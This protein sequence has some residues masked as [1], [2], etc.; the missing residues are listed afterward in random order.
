MFSMFFS[1]KLWISL[2]FLNG[3]SFTKSSFVLYYVIIYY[4]RLSYIIVWNPTLPYWIG[5]CPRSSYGLLPVGWLVG[6]ANNPTNVQCIPMTS[7]SGAGTVAG[8]PAGLLDISI[9]LSL[10]LSFSLPLSLSILSAT[11]PSARYWS[12]Y[13]LV[14]ALSSPSGVLVLRAGPPAGRTVLI[15]ILDFFS[16]EFS[17]D[18][19][20][21]KIWPK[22]PKNHPKE[23]QRGTHWSQFP[24][25]LEVPL[26]IQK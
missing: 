8:L 12:A 21:P 16:I 2:S 7:C 26:E 5:Y 15:R 17:I 4:Y 3:Y 25:I 19:L 13:S 24:V 11:V 10:S 6:I 22:G 14:S 1:I 18:V 9:S 23:S 20:S